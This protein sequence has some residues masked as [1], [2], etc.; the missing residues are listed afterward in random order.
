MPRTTY[1]VSRAGFVADPQSMEEAEGRQIDWANVA[2]GYIDAS[3]GKKVSPAGT[4]MG[5]LLGGGKKIS[6][7]VVTT[8]PA[9]CILAS[10]AVEGERSDSYSGYGI[11]VGGVVYEALLPDSTGSPKTLAAA[12]KTELSSAGCTFKFRTY[13]DNRT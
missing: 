12:L 11:Y 10:N 6:P 2:A 8:N 9:T 1:V 13:E 7:R 4:V 5:E 3:T